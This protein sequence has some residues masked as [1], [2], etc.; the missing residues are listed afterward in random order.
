MRPDED[1]ISPKLPSSS[2]N[3][4]A[5]ERVASCCRPRLRKA[6]SQPVPPLL[7]CPGPKCKS[8]AELPSSRG[9]KIVRGSGISPPATLKRRGENTEAEHPQST[10]ERQRGKVKSVG[11]EP[12]TP[13]GNWPGVGACSLPASCPPCKGDN[14]AVLDGYEG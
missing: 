5:Y 8:R 7:I 2:A 6:P 13:G 10:P 11:P 14:P 1:Q 12:D 9:H 4:K 3:P